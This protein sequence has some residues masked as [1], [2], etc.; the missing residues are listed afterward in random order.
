MF[1]QV[2]GPRTDRLSVWTCWLCGQRQIW[3]RTRA[4]GGCKQAE[5]ADFILFGGERPTI[6]KRMSFKAVMKS[7]ASAADIFGGCMR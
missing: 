3:M 2:G 5:S 6:V 7:A 4:N 1:G